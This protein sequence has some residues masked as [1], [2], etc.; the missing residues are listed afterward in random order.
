CVTGLLTRHLGEQFQCSSDTIARYFKH[1]LIFFSDD[2]FYT[3]QVRIP[4]I[5]T[6]LSP[7]ISNDP[8]FR[9]FDQCIGAVDG[10]HIQ[11]FASLSEH[12]TMHNR[13]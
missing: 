8:C 9:F 13:K 2:P 6:P 12:S 10:T 5:K 7:K 3:L 1:L 4:T 11:V